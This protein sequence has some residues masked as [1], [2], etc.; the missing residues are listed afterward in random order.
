MSYRLLW[1]ASGEP[2]MFIAVNIVVLEVLGMAQDGEAAV[3]L[4]GSINHQTLA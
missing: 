3:V 1:I 4:P 2:V